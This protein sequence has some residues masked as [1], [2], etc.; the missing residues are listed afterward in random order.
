MVCP[1]AERSDGTGSVQ[2]FADDGGSFLLT[3]GN[4]EQRSKLLMRGS[5][6]SIHAELSKQIKQS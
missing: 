6:G 1:E 4:I 5:K 2:M 3:A